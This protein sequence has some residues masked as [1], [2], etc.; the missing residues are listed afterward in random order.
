MKLCVNCNSSL[1]DESLYCNKC[2]AKQESSGA[3]EDTS[4]NVINELIQSDSP[5]SKL[6][7]PRTILYGV[8]LILFLAISVITVYFN[9][10]EQKAKATVDNY[11]KALQHG[12]YVGGFKSESFDDYINVIDFKYVNTQDS[13]EYEG[14]E[15]T[16]Y[17]REYYDKY[18]KEVYPTF[19]EFLEQEKEIHLD[20]KHFTVLEN[21]SSKIVV[22]DDRLGRSFSFLYDMQVTN[23][24]GTPVYKKVTFD[25]DNFSG[26]YKI[27]YYFDK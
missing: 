16:T 15:V 11:L 17:D 12:E 14:N 20:N 2:G 22:R 19:D 9:T 1:E 7:T 4:E 5:K 27:S 13:Y 8:A 25:V 10:P 21:D 23:G 6:L 26:E 3:S 24:L 18:L